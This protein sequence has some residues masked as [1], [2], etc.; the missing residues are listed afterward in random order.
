M[1]KEFK[2]TREKV[3]A[4]LKIILNGDA[5]AAEFT[6]LNMLAKPYQRQDG[7]LLGN[8]TINLSGMTIP[9]SRNLLKFI[10]AVLPLTLYMPLT[11]DNLEKDRYTPRKNYD[12]N[13]LEPGTFQMID[14]TFVITD[15][16]W[17]KEGQVKENGLNNIKAVAT[18]IE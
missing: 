10:Q 16:T 8:Y 1:A 7:F 13:L 14:S 6:L 11:I 17:M 2:E 5:L 3:L 12:T 4:V 15:E 9:M 18:L